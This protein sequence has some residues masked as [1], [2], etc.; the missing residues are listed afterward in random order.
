MSTSSLTGVCMTSNSHQESVHEDYDCPFFGDSH[1]REERQYDS[2]L[3]SEGPENEWLGTENQR[4]PLLDLSYHHS[5]GRVLQGFMEELDSAS[6]PA[7]C[8]VAFS[9]VPVERETAPKH[10]WRRRISQPWLDEVCEVPR[11]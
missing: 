10:V 3:E 6:F 7:T 8:Q 1:R 5:I 11:C 2:D 9:I 4:C